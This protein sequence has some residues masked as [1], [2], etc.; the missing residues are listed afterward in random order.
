MSA[1]HTMRDAELSI[2]PGA[3]QADLAPIARSHR[4]SLPRDES[5]IRR[6]SSGCAL[7]TSSEPLATAVAAMPTTRLPHLSSPSQRILA[8]S[9]SSR[10]AAPGASSLS[11]DPPESS[12]INAVET[13]SKDTRD[14]VGMRSSTPTE[15]PPARSASARATA[16]STTTGT[17]AR[18]PIG[19]TV[20]GVY[21]KTDTHS[22][23]LA[24][25]TCRD[26]DLREEI[27][28]RRCAASF[29]ASS[30]E[31]EA[32]MATIGCLPANSASDFTG[33]ESV[34]SPQRTSS[35]TLIQCRFV[36]ARPVK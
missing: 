8:S 9:L 27:G 21:P 25:R 5:M 34:A 16:L 31:V 24:I 28:S 35:S 3:F 6:R 15:P 18:W 29:S 23:G 7:P 30:L 2:S 10:S 19:G 20:P 33:M 1:C 36:L 14:T 32:T 11:A 4:R 22:S 17:R 12:A 26:T 13:K